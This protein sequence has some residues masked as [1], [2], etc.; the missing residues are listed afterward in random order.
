MTSHKFRLGQT[1]RFIRLPERKIFG[2][3]PDG[4]FRIV[5]LLPEYKGTYQYRVE[6]TNDDHN[7]VVVE[8]EIAPRNDREGGVRQ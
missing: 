4:D 8:S 5:A 1:V 3:T 2:G 6:S 7:R